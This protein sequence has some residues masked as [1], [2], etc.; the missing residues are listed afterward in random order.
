MSSLKPLNDRVLVKPTVEETVSGIIIPDSSKEKPITG[1][2]VETGG[3]EDVVVGDRIIFS[4]YGYDV[5][6]ENNEELYLISRT[7]ILAKYV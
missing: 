2:V 3:M 6:K 4:K 5:V 1:V 7:S